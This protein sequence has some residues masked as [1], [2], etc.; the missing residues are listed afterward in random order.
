LGARFV[1]KLEHFGFPRPIVRTLY[2]DESLFARAGRPIK[3]TLCRR[4]AIGAFRAIFVA[5][6]ANVH[7]ASVYL[8][9]INFI[10]ATVG[11][12]NILEEKDLEKPPEQSVTLYIVLQCSAIGLQLL[13]HRA[14]KYDP[15]PLIVLQSR[16]PK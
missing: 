12:R 4:D 6:K 16:S 7:R 14:D 8:V 1:D 13:L 3:F 2:K 5:E 10:G 11:R 15:F 9:K